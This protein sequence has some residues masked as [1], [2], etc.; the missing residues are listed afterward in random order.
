MICRI[1]F[2]CVLAFASAAV[3]ADE[4]QNVDTVRTMMELINQRDLD[5]LGTV[6]A[7]DVHRHSNA[8]PGVVVTSLDD[9]KA[10]LE[11]DFASIPDSVMD[12]DMIFG[13]GDK[14]TVRAYYSGTQ[15]GQ[16]GPFPPSG[17]AVKL[18]FIGILR[19]EN[20]KI[21]EIWVE[22]DNVSVLVQLGHLPPPAD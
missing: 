12:I 15:T 10:F 19:I 1:A 14:V 22:W 4:G 21:A 7:D 17:E 3:S 13:G 11:T 5:A 8:T 6:V 16:M 18:V 9:F 2:L 20:G